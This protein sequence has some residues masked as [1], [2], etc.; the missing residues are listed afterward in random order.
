M[1]QPTR[2]LVLAISAVT[3]L[4]ACSVAAGPSA[5]S[6]GAP[7]ASPSGALSVEGK[8]YLSTAV[9]GAVLVPG[10]RIRLSFKDGTLSASGGCN[11]MGGTYTI[12]GGRLTTT[13]MMTTDMG[14]DQPRMQQ[15]AWLAT[16]LSGSTISL[17]GDTLTLDDGT[18]QLMLQ[19]REVADPDRPIEGTNWILDGI[20]T[21]DAVSS[22]PAGVTASIRIADGQ[23]AVND[24]CNVGSGTVTVTSDSL[25]FGPLMMS[26]RPC[27]AGTAGVE[28]AVNSVLTGTVHYSI[29]ADVLTIDA[30]GSGLTYRAAP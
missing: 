14:C 13:Q 21:G 5:Q 8:T 24:G 12:A 19:D 22:V 2:F 3:L 25:T 27:Q 15:D 20:R 4:A 17:A 23:I 30:G 6:S 11:S 10:T 29:E 7:S 1:N 9:K 16:L 26:K 18:I 28:S